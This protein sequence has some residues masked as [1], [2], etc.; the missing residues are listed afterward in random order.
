MANKI[1]VWITYW[2]KVKKIAVCD[3]FFG[4]CDWFNTDGFFS[5]DK[6]IQDRVIKKT[7]E[8]SAVNEEMYVL[9]SNVT[10]LCCRKSVFQFDLKKIISEEK[11]NRECFV[12]LPFIDEEYENC[13]FYLEAVDYI[14]DFKYACVPCIK[15]ILCSIAEKLYLFKKCTIMED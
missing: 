12:D 15:N 2:E 9:I 3:C 10:V 7:I 14:D 11:L 5:L 8:K 4:C 1:S 6:N 13:V